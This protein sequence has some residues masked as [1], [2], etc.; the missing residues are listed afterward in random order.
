MRISLTKTAKPGK[1]ATIFGFLYLPFYVWGFSYALALLNWLLPR[2]LNDLQLNTIYFT[3]NALAV[4]TICFRYLLRSARESRYS[5][6]AILGYAAL[7]FVG[8]LFLTELITNLI[9]PLLPDFENLN[10]AGI[11][12]LIQKNYLLM[13]L[14]TV[15]LAPFTEELL[16]R[17]ILFRSVFQKS[18]VLAYILSMAAFSMIHLLGYD[19]PSLG[20]WV[21]AFVQYLPA[22]F[23]FAFAYHRSGSIYSAILAHMANNLLAMLLS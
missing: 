18:P 23:F 10:D 11:N 5:I 8:I 12:W 22:G 15:I 4:G 17:G 6:P 13:F 1:W 16:F 21:L 3:V 2:H 9:Y 20:H 14:F 19:Y 7:A